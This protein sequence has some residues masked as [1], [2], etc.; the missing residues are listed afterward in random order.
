MDFSRLTEDLHTPPASLRCDSETALQ[1]KFLPD[2][3]L[4][5]LWSC[6][7]SGAITRKAS[8]LARVDSITGI[9]KSIS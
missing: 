6:P 3:T 2:T 9:V 4:A 8:R 7:F 5:I 1:T